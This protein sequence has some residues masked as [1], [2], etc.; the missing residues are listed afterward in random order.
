MFLLGV[1]AVQ[2]GVGCPV[3]VMQVGVGGAVFLVSLALVDALAFGCGCDGGV[4]HYVLLPFLTPVG[5][6]VLQ[7]VGIA[8]CHARVVRHPWGVSSP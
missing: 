1:G 8:Y 6:F 7:G 3:L 4:G 5:V 2:S